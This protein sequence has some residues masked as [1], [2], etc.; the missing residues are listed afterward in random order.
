MNMIHR[1][2]D[3]ADIVK[4]SGRLVMRN[5]AGVKR[6]VRRLIRSGCNK[7]VFDLSE[8]GFA[9]STGLGV[10]IDALKQA[11][12]AGGDVLLLRLTPEVRTIIELTRLQEVFEV[13]EDEN[14]ALQ[15]LH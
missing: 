12:A 1:P 5:A 3:S 7:L 4:L 11:R 8:L 9:D 14:A 10:L 13:Y 6:E 2:M 15:A